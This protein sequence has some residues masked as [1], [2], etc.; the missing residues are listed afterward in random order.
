MCC[1]RSQ[2][3]PYWHDLAWELMG[4]AVSKGVYL[5]N[6]EH[7]EVSVRGGS[8][9]LGFMGLCIHVFHAYLYSWGMI[10]VFPFT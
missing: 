5:A 2:Q 6:A 10:G 8:G 1:W 4:L 7:R 9:E 3:E